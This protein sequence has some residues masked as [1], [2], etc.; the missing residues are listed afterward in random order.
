MILFLISNWQ[1]YWA[2]KTDAV[3]FVRHMSK[4]DNCVRPV[5]HYKSWEKTDAESFFI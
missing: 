2:Q 5:V 4:F 3:Q 1:L